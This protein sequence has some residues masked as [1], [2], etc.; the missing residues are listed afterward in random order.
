MYNNSTSP[1]TNNPPQNPLSHIAQYIPYYVP[2]FQ[3]PPQNYPQIYPNPYS[4]YPQPQRLPT[5]FNY[6]KTNFE[7]KTEENE[8][9][10]Q[11][12]Y[13][14]L[15]PDPFKNKSSEQIVNEFKAFTLPKLRL[16]RLIKLQARIK[17]WLVRRF[18]F[19]KKKIQHRLMQEY[20][21]KKIQ[22][23]VEVIKR[24]SKDFHEKI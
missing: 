21:E 20:V 19:P 10:L 7:Q 17:G 23:I 9:T 12:E 4:M 15:K 8:K 13:K 14:P 24:I 2:Y 18:L 5:P 1:P 16:H 22:E 11:N 6:S 3:Y